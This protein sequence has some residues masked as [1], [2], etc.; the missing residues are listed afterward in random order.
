MPRKNL[1]ATKPPK[2]CTRAVQADTTAQIAIHV[3]ISK[4]LVYEVR[5]CLLFNQ[6]IKTNVQMPGLIRVINMLEGI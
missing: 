6:F 1:Q 4:V 2:F 3:L 5:I